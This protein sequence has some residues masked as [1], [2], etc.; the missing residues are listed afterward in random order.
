MA[1]KA[2]ITCEKCGAA[3]FA[4]VGALRTHQKS[5][6]CKFRKQKR[7]RVVLNPVEFQ[8]EAETAETRMLEEQNG[9]PSLCSLQ[10]LIDLEHERLEKN[11]DTQEFDSTVHL[12][13]F[14]RR[15]RNQMGL[16][17]SDIDLLLKTLFHPLF[18]LSEVAFR[19]ALEL[20]QYE[21]ASI[22]EDD[23]SAITH[24]KLLYEFVML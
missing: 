12:L 19:T 6:K 23:V 9:G 11:P 18:V 22:E 2:Q 4:N 13:H 16:S 21:E 3:N 20:E 15:C 14:I 5:G 8:R 17:K 24:Y 10:A 1:P 7:P